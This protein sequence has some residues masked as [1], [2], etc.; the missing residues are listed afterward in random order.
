M[1]LKNLKG[2]K[3]IYDD[4]MC[5]LKIDFMEKLKNVILI[6]I[7]SEYKLIC[8]FIYSNWNCNRNIVSVALINLNRYI[9]SKNWDQ[10]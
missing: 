9:K 1:C 6:E 7:N 3:S 10:E 5:K 4:K 2:I 8:V